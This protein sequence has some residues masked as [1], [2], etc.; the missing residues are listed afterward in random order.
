MVHYFNETCLSRWTRPRTIHIDSISTVSTFCNHPKG[1][2]WLGWLWSLSRISL[3]VYHSHA[4]H[5]ETKTK[6]CLVTEDWI[7]L[8][9]WW[10]VDD[11]LE[12]WVCGVC[13]QTICWREAAL[14]GAFAKCKRSSQVCQQSCSRDTRVLWLPTA[15]EIK[16]AL[17][18]W[19]ACLASTEIEK[20]L[21][22]QMCQELTDQ[23]R[24]GTPLEGHLVLVWRLYL[25]SHRLTKV[26]VARF[27]LGLT[28][29]WKRRHS[30]IWTRNWMTTL[31]NRNETSIG[32]GHT[33]EN[34]S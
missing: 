13:E 21:Y 34:G 10:D 3:W 8:E 19:T 30:T 25:I 23:Y 16:F 15:S 32:H 7:N 1:H 26:V 29:A 4:T 18:C 17:L 28:L 14:D 31:L 11:F 12:V 20:R 33:R 5:T 2:C 6:P 24:V 27:D 22:W 9:F